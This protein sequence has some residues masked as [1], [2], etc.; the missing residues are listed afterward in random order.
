MEQI[1]NQSRIRVHVVSE[2]NF[3]IK[4]NGVHT[5][6]LDHISLLNLSNKVETVVN[7][8]GDGKNKGDIMHSHTYGLYY[9]VKGLR[10]RNKKILT[11]HVTPDSIKGSLPA[12]K[13]FMPFVKWY[14]K[15]VYNYAD[16]CIAISPRVEESIRETGAKTYVARVFNPIDTD[17][18]HTTPEKRAKGRE[19]LGLDQNDFVV[20]G[21]GQLQSRK[22]VEDF[23]KIAASVPN[24]KFVWA[25]GRPFGPMTEGIIRIDKQISKTKGTNI[26]FTGMVDLEMM[27]YI[28]SSADLMLFTSYQENCPLA[29]IEAAAANLPVV[30]RDI[31]EYVALYEHKYLKAA[32]TEAFIAY[33]K[34]LMDDPEEY[35]KAKKIS[36]ELITQFDKRNVLA[37][38]LALYEF[39]N[40]N[41][42]HKVK[43]NAIPVFL[44]ATF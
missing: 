32:N 20:L 27:K 35:Q 44:H 9:F 6:F 40:N 39:L 29:P 23:M 28:Y 36:E 14:F 11:V 30:F 12:W 13:F 38:L 17:Y 1:K 31:N 34:K 42:I 3:M 19:F 10:Y 33:T 37:K 8:H 26:Q 22:G 4:G 16:V 5:A 15:Q 43:K 41:N 21:V 2:T 18:W 25:G 7:E 24:A